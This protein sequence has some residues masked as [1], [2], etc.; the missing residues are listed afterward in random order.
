M[1]MPQ[2]IEQARQ[3]NLTEITGIKKQDLICQGTTPDCV[4][5]F[6][7]AA[8]RSSRSSFSFFPSAVFLSVTARIARH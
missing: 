2:L 3:E 6:V 5:F 4:S 1:T 8:G 7:S